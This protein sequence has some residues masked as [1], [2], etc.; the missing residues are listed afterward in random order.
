MEEGN[1]IR[2]KRNI[3]TFKMLSNKIQIST[4]NKYRNNNMQN[5]NNKKR[6]SSKIRV[7]SNKKR[8][9]NKNNKKKKELNRWS[10]MKT[11]RENKNIMNRMN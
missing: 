10:N 11:M 7:Q 4:S 8:S 3:I 1:S 6:Y 2:T 9:N 5:I